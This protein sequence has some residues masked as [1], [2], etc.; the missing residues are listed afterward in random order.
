MNDY[1]ELISNLR[2]YAEEYKSGRTLGRAI[3][4]TEDVML[5]AAKAIETLLAERDA[6][7]EYLRGECDYCVYA[8]MDENENPCAKCS[9]L[10]HVPHSKNRDCRDHWQ[11][12]GIGGSDGT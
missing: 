5:D 4:E 8:D 12:H 3:I 11:W 9:A 1:K 10:Y 6:A 7:V 2:W